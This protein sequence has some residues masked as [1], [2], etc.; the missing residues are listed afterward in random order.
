MGFGTDCAPPPSD[1]LRSLS[2]RHGHACSF[3]RRPR[4]ALVL[5]AAVKLLANPI[6]I[7]MALVLLAAAFAFFVG[8]A[9]IRRMR[10]SLV[11]STSISEERPSQEALPLATYHAVIQQ[12]KQ[13]KHELLTAQQAD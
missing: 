13:Q 11:E 7:R 12:L 3:L 4:P 6:V 8:L 10:R 9:I 1:A 5:G 2:R